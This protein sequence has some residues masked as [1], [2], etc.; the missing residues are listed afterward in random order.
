S[1][2]PEVVA[3]ARAREVRRRGEPI[4]V[5]LA[6]D[7]LNVGVGNAVRLVAGVYDLDIQ[8]H[9]VD[10]PAAALGRLLGRHRPDLEHGRAGRATHV[11][12]DGNLLPPD[13]HSLVAHLHRLAGARGGAVLDS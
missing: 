6:E 11:A 1:G 9:R 7:V 10:R 3:R 8:A 12:G 13:S 5:A 2:A 4:G